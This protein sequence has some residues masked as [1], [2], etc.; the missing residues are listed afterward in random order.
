M[1]VQSIATKSNQCPMC[2]APCRSNA[3]TCGVCLFPLK[4]TWPQVTGELG[5]KSWA[6]L[7]M[8]VALCV[9]GAVVCLLGW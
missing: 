7:K 3:L 8:V 9:A 5:G 4:A 6:V 2:D 1:G